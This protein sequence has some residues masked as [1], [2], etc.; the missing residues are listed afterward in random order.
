MKTMD[1]WETLASEESISKT[2]AALKANGITAVVVENGEEAKK[3]VFEIIP[4]GAEVMTM[5]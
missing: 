4:K 5:T 1:K 2:V 3:K